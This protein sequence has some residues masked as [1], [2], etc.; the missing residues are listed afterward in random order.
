MK[1][2][3]VAA[4]DIESS[5]GQKVEALPLDLA[6]TGQRIFLQLRFHDLYDLELY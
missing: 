5:T 3:Q 4:Q 6:D 2:A 1:K